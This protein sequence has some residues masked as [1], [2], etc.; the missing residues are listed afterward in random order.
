MTW[1]SSSHHHYSPAGLGAR[2]GVPNRRAYVTTTPVPFRGGTKLRRTAFARSNLLAEYQA[3]VII[4]VLVL[5][6][7]SAVAA[8]DS[9]FTEAESPGEKGFPAAE[10]S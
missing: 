2:S 8:N 6:A 10:T 5:T 3:A 1:I 7:G 9:P 4:A